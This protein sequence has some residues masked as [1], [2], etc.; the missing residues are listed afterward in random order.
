[1]TKSAA[2]QARKAQEKRQARLDREP[3]VLD[4]NYTRQG[5]QVLGPIITTDITITDSHADALRQAGQALPKKVACRFLVDTGAVGSVVKHEIAVQAGLK[6][7][8]ANRPLQGV[9][10][11]TT[12]RAYIGRIVFGVK[13]AI[14]PD[15]IHN[16]WIDTEVTGATLNTDLIDGLIG[17]DVLQHFE[18]IY[19]GRTGRVK[20]KYHRPEMP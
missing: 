6:L 17:R 10:I 3:L 15:T 14:S 8:N 7:I 2:R 9:G 19:D 11:D 16:M 12:G 20:M 18:L 1:M 5:L 13:S 4:F